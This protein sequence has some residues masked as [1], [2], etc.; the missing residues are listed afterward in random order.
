MN[1]NCMI[2]EDKVSKHKHVFVHVL[3]PLHDKKHRTQNTTV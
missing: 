2:A 1:I 3:E